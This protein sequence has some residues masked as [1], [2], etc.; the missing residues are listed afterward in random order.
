MKKLFLAVLLGAAAIHAHA[1]S[2]ADEEQRQ[3]EAE[4]ASR[5]AAGNGLAAACR[6]AIKGRRV[7]VVIAQRTAQGLLADQEAYAPHFQAIDRRLRK[8][9]LET[10]TQAEMKA[11]VAQAEIDA[12]LRNDMEAALGASR[13]MGADFVVRGM[14]STR[15][16]VNPLVRIPEVYVAM[17]FTLSGAEG[18]SVAAADAQAESYSGADTGSMALTVINEQA[19]GVIARLFRDYCSASGVGAKAR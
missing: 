2:F 1:F 7:I 12:Y 9:G 14:I 18:R 8:L 19:D 11:R 15:T 3:H 5:P 6:R 16:A 10:F 13:R 17:N 4:A